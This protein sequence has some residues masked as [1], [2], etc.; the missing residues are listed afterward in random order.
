MKTAS[1][2]LSK[3]GGSSRPL[4]GLSSLVYLGSDQLLESIF[5]VRN[6]YAWSYIKPMKLL[7]LPLLL[8][9]GCSTIKPKGSPEFG[10]VTRKVDAVEQAV[11]SGDLPTIKKEFGSL[12]SQLS[13]AQ[14]A[15]EAQAGDYERIAKEANDWKAKQRKALKELWIYRGALIALALWIF[16]GFIFGGIM[17]VARKFVGIPW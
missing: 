2:K 14:A 7:I 13:S 4:S 6:Y 5:L 17:F 1:E 9:V 15:C 11:N 16:R 8:L 10:G 12:K 3:L